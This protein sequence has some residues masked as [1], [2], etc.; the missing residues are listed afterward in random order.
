MYAP[1]QNK[2]N[3]QYIV[4]QIKQMILNEEL[5]VGD[6]LPAE[7]ELSEMYQV[8]RASVREAL[9]ALEVMGLLESRQ[10]GGTFIVNKLKE[11]MSDNLSLLFV[12]DHCS[13]RDLANL[14]Y[15]FE[16]EIIRESIHKKD[17]AVRKELEEMC[18]QIEAATDSQSLETVDMRFH[19]LIA[20]MA[21]NPLMEY[22]QASIH[23]AYMN[24]IKW[25]NESYPFWPAWETTTLE[26][27]KSYQ[28]EIIDAM[29]SE[30]IPTIEKALAAHYAY[31]SAESDLDIETIYAQ[32]QQEKKG[33][34]KQSDKEA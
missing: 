27:N 31:Y 17:P 7:R 6:H 18:R 25:L 5:T 28:R 33:G 24:N 14:R 3:Y 10:G 8:S 12:L 4:D 15:T 30:D 9:K 21:T 34:A 32:Y 19:T 13:V 23:T 16:M 20:S 1:I 11:Q 29:L 2:N 22:L 26:S